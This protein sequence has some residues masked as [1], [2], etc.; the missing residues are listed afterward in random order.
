MWLIGVA[1]KSNDSSSY[2][3]CHS[4]P[5]RDT[6][7]FFFAVFN[8]LVAVIARS[9]GWKSR[10][11]CF[12]VDNDN[13]DNRWTNRLLWSL[14]CSQNWCVLSVLFLSFQTKIVIDLNLKTNFSITNYCTA[15]FLQRNNGEMQLSATLV[16]VSRRLF[17]RVAKTALG[18]YIYIF[19]FT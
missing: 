6:P 1:N 18:V 8:S 4:I 7:V 15:D 17:Q 16:S 19:P 5:G 13:N 9:R 14:V 12:R 2:S 11:G 10:L 3:H